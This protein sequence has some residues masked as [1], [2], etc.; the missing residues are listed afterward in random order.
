M[1]SVCDSTALCT[2]CDCRPAAGSFPGCVWLGVCGGDLDGVVRFCASEAWSLGVG[3]GD[4]DPLRL[5]AGEAC[6]P[7]GGL[8]MGWGNLYGFRSCL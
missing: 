5:C 7:R 2:T 6:C 1:A 3:D 4:L 8:G